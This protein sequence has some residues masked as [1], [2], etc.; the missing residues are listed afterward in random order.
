MLRSFS[1]LLVEEVLH[2]KREK[3]ERPKPR[4][5]TS[6]RRLRKRRCVETRS[7]GW[8]VRH[9]GGGRKSE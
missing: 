3:L 9:L 1:G 5:Q 6:K 8:A 2:E 4:P 7:A